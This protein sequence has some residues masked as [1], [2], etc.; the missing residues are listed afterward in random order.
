M[1]VYISWFNGSGWTKLYGFIYKM[2]IETGAKEK[3]MFSGII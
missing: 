2:S 3:K 1:G